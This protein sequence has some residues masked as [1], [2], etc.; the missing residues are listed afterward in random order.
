M[1]DRPQQTFEMSAADMVCGTWQVTRKVIDHRAR[2]LYG[3]TGRA[4]I[5]REFFEERGEMSVGT[6][7]LQAVRTYRL[8][9]EDAAVR[10]LYPSGN[11]FVTLGYGASQRVSHLCGSD[12]YNGRFLFESRDAWVEAWRVHGPQKRY[13][14]LSWYVRVEL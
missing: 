3:F 10:L 9:F 2:A 1:L 5:T 13:S 7:V 11:E 12:H 14:S 4:V 6:N 8:V